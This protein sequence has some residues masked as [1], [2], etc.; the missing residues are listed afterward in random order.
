MPAE[1]INVYEIH[2]QEFPGDL[3]QK[4][5]SVPVFIKAFLHMFSF[6]KILL[7]MGRNVEGLFLL[8]KGYLGIELNPILRSFP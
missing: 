4:V 7:S 5:E 6:D 2:C 8:V 1:L 3:Q